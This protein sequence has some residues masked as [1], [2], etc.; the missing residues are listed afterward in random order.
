MY[1]FSETGWL[2]HVIFHPVEGFE[3]LRWKK[4]GSLKFTAVIIFMLFFSML[5]EYRLQGFQYNTHYTKIFNVVPLVMR[6]VIFY[7]AWCVG[8]W[9]I[10]TLFD[11]EGTFR[12]ICIY[13]SY[14]LVPFIVFSLVST[15]LSNFLILDESVWI[16]FFNIL[17]LLWSFVLMVQAMRAVHQ[18]SLGKTLVS[19]IATVAAMFVLLF[20]LVLILLLFQQVYNFVYT[21]YMEIQY[22]II[23]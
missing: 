5:A 16:D 12:N 21:V 6:S 18:Y 3:D 23:G 11:G 17:G 1:E 20:L 7:F 14:S 10:C 9:S 13:T 4:K 22:R 19:M 15:L 2:K 8:N